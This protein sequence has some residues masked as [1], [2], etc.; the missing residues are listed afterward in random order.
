MMAATSV[1]LSLAALAPPVPRFVRAAIAAGPIVKTLW[2]VTPARTVATLVVL[3]TEAWLDARRD[4]RAI[5]RY[6]F[7]MGS[8]M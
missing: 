2:A 3:K 5:E 1:V 8:F 7:M 6:P 4:I